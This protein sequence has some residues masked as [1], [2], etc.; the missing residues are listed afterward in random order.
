MV[1]MTSETVHQAAVD[2]LTAKQDVDSILQGLRS[3]VDALIDTWKGQGSTAFTG[4]ME[5]WDTESKDLMDALE[6]I[7]NMLDSSATAA[8]E[9]DEGDASNFAGLL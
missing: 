8:T 1:A 7:A 5:V 3:L 2:S 6:N 4:V 9:T